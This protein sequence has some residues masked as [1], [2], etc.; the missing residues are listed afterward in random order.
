MSNLF[1]ISDTHFSHTNILKFEAEARPFNTLEEHDEELITRWNSRV[2]PDDRLIHLGDVCFKPATRLGAIMSRLNGKKTLVLGNHD[3]APMDEYMK[4][5]E[6]IMV[7]YKIPK[8]NV[9][10][11]HY[12]MHPCQL[13]NRYNINV[14]G[15]CHS[16]HVDDPRYI[17]ISC[18]N[19]GLFPI[20][21]DELKQRIV[22]ENGKQALST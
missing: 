6:R 16:F 10:C 7:T 13:E 19:T 15:H 9:I 11:S 12:P 2:Q 22:D 21:L 3:V 18:E 14:H 5:F 1:F 20:S 4:W 8:T 17:N